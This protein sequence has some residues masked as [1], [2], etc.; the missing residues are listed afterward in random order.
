MYLDSKSLI[1]DFREEKIGPKDM[2]FYANRLS[3]RERKKF[4]S[5]A[6][7]LLLIKA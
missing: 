4:V 1:S 6:R 3:S 7:D 5:K 2:F